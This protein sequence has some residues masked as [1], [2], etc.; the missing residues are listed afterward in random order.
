MLGLCPPAAT[1]G[2]AGGGQLIA[3]AAIGVAG[4]VSRVHEA[5]PVQIWDALHEACR[6]NTTKPWIVLHPHGTSQGST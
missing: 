5:C 2:Q 1:L 3:E 4:E 6:H